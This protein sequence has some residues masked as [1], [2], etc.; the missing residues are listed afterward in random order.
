VILVT[1]VFFDKLI[2][3]DGIGHNIIP[4]ISSIGFGLSVIINPIVYLGLKA[5]VKEMIRKLRTYYLL[6][7]EILS[8]SF[9]F[10][11]FYSAYWSV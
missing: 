4:I 3:I 7:T 6:M 8:T 9:C 5:N 10:I 1:F 2:R 11:I